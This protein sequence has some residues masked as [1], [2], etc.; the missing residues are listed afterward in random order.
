MND[1]SSRPGSGSNPTACAPRA[2]IAARRAPRRGDAVT[3]ADGLDRV[4]A[5][6]ETGSDPDEDL[7][8]APRRGTP[9]A[10]PSEVP[11]A[12]IGFAEFP[13]AVSGKVDRN[14]I[15]QRLTEALIHTP[16]EERA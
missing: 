13:V 2:R 10:A 6:L 3:D 7:T 14:E 9:H 15:R 16:H 8:H 12:L 4:G 5:A 11:R 1:A